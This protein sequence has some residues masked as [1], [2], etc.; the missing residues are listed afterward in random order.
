MSDLV[1]RATEVIE[2][3]TAEVKGDTCPICIS[4]MEDPARLPCNHIFCTSCIDKWLKCGSFT[5][6]ICRRDPNVEEAACD[7]CNDPSTAGEYQQS[8]QP[9]VLEGVDFDIF[10]VQ[11]NCGRYICQNCISASSNEDDDRV[12]CRYCNEAL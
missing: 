7:I 3:A 11:C 12:V 2:E 6:P 8:A 5:C 9:R 10:L 1:P 4:E